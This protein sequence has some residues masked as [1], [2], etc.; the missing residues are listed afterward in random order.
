ME[1]GVSLLFDVGV[2]FVDGVPLESWLFLALAATLFSVTNLSKTA[3]EAGT[4]LLEEGGSVFSCSSIA[5]E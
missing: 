5:K 4:S 1:A 2:L 3:A